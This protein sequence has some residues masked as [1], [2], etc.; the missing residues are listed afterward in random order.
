MSAHRYDPDSRVQPRAVISEGSGDVR[1]RRNGDT[2]VFVKP[3]ALDGDGEFHLTVA[4]I[5]EALE[6]LG[7]G[8]RD[9]FG[10]EA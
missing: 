4:N 5:G 7:F 10:G 1:V 6:L 9:V 3:E 8:V 2:G